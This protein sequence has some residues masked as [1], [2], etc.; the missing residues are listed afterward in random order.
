MSIFAATIISELAGVDGM[1]YQAGVGVA[2]TWLACH[3]VLVTSAG[4]KYATGS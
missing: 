1:I 3:V 4:A 2:L